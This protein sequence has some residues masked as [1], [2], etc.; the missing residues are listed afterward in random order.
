[1]LTINR[2]QQSGLT[3]VELMVGVVVGLIVLAG[4]I[5]VYIATIQS[6]NSMLQQAKLSQQMRA[7]LAIMTSDIRRA[8]YWGTATSGTFSNPFA[9]IGDTD[10]NVRDG[11]NAAVANG[12]SGT[13]ILF[14]YDKNGDGSVGADEYYG[15]R[16]SGGTNPVQV[17]YGGASAG[18]GDD[19]T[20]G[21]WDDLTDDRSLTIDSL[22]FSLSNV[23]CLNVTT[24]AD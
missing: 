6:S 3:I 19:C 9:T 14:S 10:I 13:C 12:A 17:R 11:S 8:G 23:K 16:W 15:Y 4:V 1:M 5:A 21:S 22:G 2:R 18:D 24:G 7:S 20:A